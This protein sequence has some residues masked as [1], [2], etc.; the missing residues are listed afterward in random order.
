LSTFL[1]KYISTPKGLVLYIEIR[2]TKQRMFGEF[3]SIARLWTSLASGWAPE[4]IESASNS[5]GTCYPRPEV[6]TSWSQNP[7]GETE[8]THTWAGASEM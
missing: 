3:S 5:P 6:E 4:A 7:D 8:V 2:S 1:L